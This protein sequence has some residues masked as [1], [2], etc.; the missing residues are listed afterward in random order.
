MNWQPIDTAPI[1]NEWVELYR[2]AP[3]Y[4]V[5][6]RIVVARWS[7]A[8]YAWVWPDETYD[9]LDPDN[10]KEAEKMIADGEHYQATSF[11]HWRPHVAPDDQG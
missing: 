9:V 5:A 2:P 4:G 7:G 10:R 11:T 3:A 6:E 1:D 8:D